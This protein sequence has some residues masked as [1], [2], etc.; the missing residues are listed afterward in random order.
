M[1]NN[2]ENLQVLHSLTTQYDTIKNY[3]KEILISDV[4]QA[5]KTINDIELIIEKIKNHIYLDEALQVVNIESYVGYQRISNILQEIEERFPSLIFANV[6][7]PTISSLSR[8]SKNPL[9][10]KELKIN[11]ETLKKIK[12]MNSDD[13][14]KTQ[15]SLSVISNYFNAYVNKC[16]A[17]LHSSYNQ[18]FLDLS[19]EIDKQLPNQNIPKKS[20]SF[21]DIGKKIQELIPSRSASLNV[22]NPSAKDLEPQAYIQPSNSNNQMEEQKQNPEP[23]QQS[24]GMGSSQ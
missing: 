13:L 1:E 17:D 7:A 20:F 16:G 12:K 5:A 10:S 15:Q 3:L 8:K 6:I 14:K 22:I 23:E 4:N 19:N 2:T 11:D 21:S 9:S 18:I 24:Y